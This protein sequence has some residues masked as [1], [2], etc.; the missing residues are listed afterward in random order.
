MAV[1]PIRVFGDPVLRARAAE[2]TEFTPELARLVEDMM[3]T[4]DAH[5]GAGLA[6][7]QVGV[8][9]RVFTFS[10]GGHRGHIINP[11]WTAEGTEQQTDFEGCL[12]IPG[13]RARCTRHERVTVRG[14]DR[15][16][17]PISITAEG[18][19][20][21]CVQHETDHLDGVLFLQRLDAPV[22]KEAMRAVRHSQWFAADI[23]ITDDP[24]SYPIVTVDSPQVAA[25]QPES[26]E[27]ARG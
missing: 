20:A 4:M 13:I 15:D 3:E 10:C 21:R 12:S 14:V 23:T 18:I 17:A 8:E 26:A 1:L 9:A 16:G 25:A 11:V 24:G 5:E 6:A 22:R 19:M 7:T 2:V 27:A